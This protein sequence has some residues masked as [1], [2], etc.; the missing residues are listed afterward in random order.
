M[1]VFTM[2]VVRKLVGSAK[3]AFAFC[4][5]L[6]IRLGLRMTNVEEERI[7]RSGYSNSYRREVV[8]IQLEG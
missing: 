4:S 1:L 3:L 7:A 6:P 8:R 2:T 5:P